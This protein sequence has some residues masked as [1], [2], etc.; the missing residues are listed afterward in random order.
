MTLVKLGGTDNFLFGEEV[1]VRGS[2]S[3]VLKT[4]LLHNTLL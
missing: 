2:F 3:C 4:L 1:K